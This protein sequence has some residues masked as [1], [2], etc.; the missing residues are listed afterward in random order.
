MNS[1]EAETSQL[2]TMPLHAITEVF[3]TDGLA[4]RFS[5][6]VSKFDIEAQQQINQAFIVAYELHKED[7]RVREPYINHP[8]R[9]ATRIMTYYR[10][11]DP[12]VISAALLHDC[13]EDHSK[14]LAHDGTKATALS[15]IEDWF[16]PRV[17]ELVGGV[18]NPDF[19]PNRDKDEQYLEHLIELARSNDPW[20]LVI[21]I[22]DFTDNATG[23]IYTSGPKVK[24][25][26]NKYQPV[27]PVLLEASNRSDFPLD[28][29]AVIHIQQQLSLTQDRLELLAA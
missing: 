4:T 7:N 2:A 14:E 27:T 15:V 16:N 25:L 20:L 18:T 13:V 5:L 21:K 28:E 3:G 1:Y 11:V 26:A 10:V 17:A 29:I 24:K 12:D 22:S 9:V 23:L 19:D 6:E 8:L